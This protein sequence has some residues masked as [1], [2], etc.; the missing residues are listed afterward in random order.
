MRN[1]SGSD[2]NSS[3]GGIDT[4]SPS[5]PRC[6]GEFATLETVENRQHRMNGAS[7]PCRLLEVEIDRLALVLV[8]LEHRRL[9]PLELVAESVDDALACI[10]RCVEHCPGGCEWSECGHLRTRPEALART[11][12]HCATRLADG[13]RTASADDDIDSADLELRICLVVS[14][15]LHRQDRALPVT[16][17]PWTLVPLRHVVHGRLWEVERNPQL[18]HF[19]CCRV[20]Q[21]HPH[22]P[23]G[24]IDEAA[25]IAQTHRVGDTD[26]GQ[27]ARALGDHDGTMLPLRRSCRWHRRHGDAVR[28]VEGWLGNLGGVSPGQRDR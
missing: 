28:T 2:S 6:F 20:A 14:C 7:E 17:E 24:L 12:E 3:G 27:V 11:F 15:G 5:I 1:A 25:R 26:T 19:A 21:R 16:L 13:D 10:N 23:V 18:L 9:N 8:T 4:L 22:E